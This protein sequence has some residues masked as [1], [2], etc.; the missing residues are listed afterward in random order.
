MRPCPAPVV[1]WL[2]LA[3]RF[4]VLHPFFPFELR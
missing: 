2:I 4:L 1:I 3:R